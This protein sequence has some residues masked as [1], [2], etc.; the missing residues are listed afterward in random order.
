M[1][2]GGDTGLA[3]EISAHAESDYQQ[4]EGSLTPSY[5]DTEVYA[6]R[7]W[8]QD[9]S[10][11]GY[12]ARPIPHGHILDSQDELLISRYRRIF[13]IRLTCNLLGYSPLGLEFD[14]L[15]GVRGLPSLPIVSRFLIR[16]NYYRNIQASSLAQIIGSLPCLSMCHFKRWK[17]CDHGREVE[18]I[19]GKYSPSVSGKSTN[20][21]SRCTHDPGPIAKDITESSHLQQLMPCPTHCE[22]RG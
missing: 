12:Y 6:Y 11:R 9:R 22:P 3:L 8:L 1:E 10:L 14:G 7:K 5:F 17:C 4:T 21:I 13:P 19:Q 2:P 20:I 18:W 16:R 15:G